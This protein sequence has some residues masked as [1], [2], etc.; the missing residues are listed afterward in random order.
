[1]SN[2]EKSVNTP[3]VQS[4]IVN[5]GEFVQ[6]GANGALVVVHSG[7][8][9][10]V[11]TYQADGSLAPAAAGGY[12]TLATELS[13]SSG[14]FTANSWVSLDTSSLL[15]DNSAGAFTDNGN[16]TVTVN[17]VASSVFVIVTIDL[18]W[19]SNGGTS[20]WSAHRSTLNGSGIGA[21]DSAATPLFST[22]ATNTVSRY[23]TQL[24]T[25]D[26]V[27]VQVQTNATSEGLSNGQLILELVKLVS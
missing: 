7:A 17:S 27:G 26:V 23:V 11:P 14:T 25:G 9:G 21:D 13:F 10:Q 1:M 22:I 4:L 5:P 24:H 15:A 6:R 3:I 19:G 16:G 20:K 18:V 8:A 2:P 12:K